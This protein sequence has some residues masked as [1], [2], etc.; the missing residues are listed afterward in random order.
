M[1]HAFLAIS[2]KEFLHAARNPI[3]LRIHI[4]LQV[5][6]LLMMG[7]VNFTVRNLPTVI[8][9]QDHSVE[10]REFISRVGATGTFRVK[11][12]TSSVAQ[13]RAH[14][15]AGRASVA[16][17]IPPDYHRDR[18][19]HANSRVQALVDGSDS[20]TSTQAVAAIDGIA[21][22]MNRELGE[23]ASTT[24][25]VRTVI[26]HSMLMFNPEGRTSNFMLPAMLA[27][28]MTGFLI[29]SSR[30][31][32]A[33]RDGGT[34]ERLMMTPMNYTGLILGKL[35]P[36]F[37]LGVVNGLGY[38]VVMRWIFGVP[39]RGDMLALIVAVIL[40]TLTLLS[41]G[42]FIAASSGP[43]PEA[44]LAIGIVITGAF[45]LSGYFFPVRSL[46][47]I[48]RPV[49]YALPATHMI[50]IMR[51]TCLRGSTLYDLLPHFVYLIVAPVVFTF[52]A[53]RKFAASIIT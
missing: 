50:E 8:V 38:L 42:M 49:S 32:L 10:S 17:V 52:A 28:I 22:T 30:A 6:D 43:G 12:T 13:A 36:Y 29:M 31:L 3:V 14:L 47:L 41:L 23:S 7:F 51:G 25:P 1:W 46:P 18:V 21:S 37:V 20:V 26:A 4:M 2:Y 27:I 40:Y 34:L 53:A 48:L 44:Q 15:Q 35:A 9:D 39:I 45:L 19:A 5:M 11:Y 24:V 16:L 33:E